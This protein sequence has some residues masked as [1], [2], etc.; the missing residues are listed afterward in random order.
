MED[1][2]SPLPVYS[3]QKY[4]IRHLLGRG[5]YGT[6]Y[7]AFDT[8]FQ[9]N[10]AIKHVQI[11]DDGVGYM[12]KNEILLTMAANDVVVPMLDVIIPEDIATLR[13]VFLVAELMHAD[14]C[15]VLRQRRRLSLADARYV[16][17]RLLKA[18]ATIHERGIMHRDIKLENVLLRADDDGRVDVRLCDMGFAC[19]VVD[20][21]KMDFTGTLAYLAP[22]RLL[23]TI[24][25]VRHKSEYGTEMDMWSVGCVMAELLGATLPHTTT[26]VDVVAQLEMM[27]KTFGSLTEKEAAALMSKVFNAS[28]VSRLQARRGGGRL[29]RA[30]HSV[31]SLWSTLVGAGVPV[32]ALDLMCKLLCYDPTKR[33]SAEQALNHGFFASM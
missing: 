19:C 33:W 1:D 27:H 6:I 10:V 14:L 7:E 22:E 24:D 29:K 17:H 23:N 2:D 20:Q 18:V 30:R 3:Q 31:G 8:V 12:T 25:D 21:P 13:E 5:A 28:L 16:V 15:D 32:D 4:H 26:G 9:R 11:D